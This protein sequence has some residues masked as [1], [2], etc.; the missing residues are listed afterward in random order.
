[1]GIEI[2]D[3]NLPLAII[4]RLLE[5]SIFPLTLFIL[6]LVILN[7]TRSRYSIIERFQLSILFGV[8]FLIFAFGGVL[9]TSDVLVKAEDNFFSTVFGVC[10]LGLSLFA[11]R[12]SE[13]RG[14]P[15]WTIIPWLLVTGLTLVT[16]IER[17]LLVFR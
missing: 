16:V 14:I 2:D 5:A 12:L 9:M 6:C 1:M 4:M 17:I 8:V 7:V 11:F 15:W 10:G 13:F 3:K